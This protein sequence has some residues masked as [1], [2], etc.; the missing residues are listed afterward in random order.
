MIIP[1]RPL[2]IPIDKEVPAP[3]YNDVKRVLDDLIEKGETPR[4]IRLP[5]KELRPLY[6]RFFSSP[7]RPTLFGL[8][9]DFGVADEII[10][11]RVR[12]RGI[13]VNV[14][15]ANKETEH[16]DPAVLTKGAK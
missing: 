14:N 7:S 3:I 8:T 9:V 12:N 4:H 13:N 2:F 6:E 1:I 11:L 16:W 15:H 5:A 10:V